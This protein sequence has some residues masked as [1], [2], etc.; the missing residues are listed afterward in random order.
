MSAAYFQEH[1]RVDFIMEGGG[2]S[3][4]WDICFFFC[5]FV[6]SPLVRFRNHINTSRA[7]KKMHLKMSSDEVA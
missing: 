7:M 4:S 6:I 1:S 2:G 3:L 5:Y